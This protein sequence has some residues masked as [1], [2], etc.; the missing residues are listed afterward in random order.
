MNV[1]EVQLAKDREAIAR[2]I[3]S[4]LMK[5]V[6]CVEARTMLIDCSIPVED[7]ASNGESVRGKVFHI[8]CALCA[9]GSEA[10][11]ELIRDWCES[12]RREF[13]RCRIG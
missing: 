9:Q 3:H 1:P 13:P 4:L 7:L 8:A 5:W 11:Q 12:E 2:E 6:L 10:D